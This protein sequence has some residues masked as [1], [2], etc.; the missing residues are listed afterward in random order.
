MAA[1][2]KRLEALRQ[3]VE[4]RRCARDPEH[5][6]ATYCKV[7]HPARGLIPFELRDAQRETLRTVM[8]NQKVII[9]KARQ[10]GFSTL[11]ANY[12][13]WRA[14]F[15]PDQLIII[16]SRRGDDATDFLSKAKTAY[17]H[18]PEWMRGRLPNTR[19]HMQI[20][21]F[22]NG[23][24]IESFP[25][26]DNP[27]RGRS[28]SLIIVDEWAFLENPE[29][30]WASI[31]PI[32]DIGGDIVG[33]STANGSGD[34]F[35]QMWI[36]A[37]TG[38]SSFVPIFFPFNA[39]PERD[40][41]WYEQKQL[42][43][44]PWQLAQEYPRSEDEAFIKSG[45]P[46]FDVDMLDA[47]PTVE[48]KRGFLW[49]PNPSRRYAEFR[50]SPNG[51]LRLWEPP[52]EG[53][54]YVVGADVAEGLEHG[55][56]SVAAVVDNQS[57]KLVAVWHGHIDPDLFGSDVLPQLG[58]WYRNA[59]IGVEVNNHGLT[60]LKALQRAGYENIYHRE[61]HDQ[62]TLQVTRKIGWRTQANTKPLLVDDLNRALRDGTLRVMDA[63]TIAELKTFVRDEKGGMHGSPYDDR[64]I[65]LGIA[66][67]M[68]RWVFAPE[69][70]QDVNDE[71][72]LDWWARQGDEPE[73]GD[74]LI[75]VHS[76]Y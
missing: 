50:P 3:E 64:T 8:A 71:W 26:K 7:R 53:G 20:M 33:L 10:I 62:R 28:A 72:T 74:W 44:L 37:R 47:M 68:R 27:A 58:W 11:F 15:R 45:N 14:M 19:D 4:W 13:L 1:D 56:F 65:A 32:A 67:Q 17:D 2:R 25:S 18:L 5:F 57:G 23:S 42:D 21:E 59:L 63:E 34:F 39:V 29:E 49:I 16:L 73:T 6:F 46:V 9:L 35:H 69:Y 55:D 54:V 66:E 40:D 48:P 60:T 75:G 52:T 38:A 12:V 22:P 30:A 70:Q 24:R 61:L 36:K 76:T 41:A 31:E 43:L 51:E